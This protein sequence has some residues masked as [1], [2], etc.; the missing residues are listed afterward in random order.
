LLPEVFVPNAEALS[1][2]LLL[3]Y[4]GISSPAQLSAFL[5]NLVEAVGDKGA[6]FREHTFSTA[7]DFHVDTADLSEMVGYSEV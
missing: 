5:T 7:R 2:L 3:L 6:V 4:E 1:R